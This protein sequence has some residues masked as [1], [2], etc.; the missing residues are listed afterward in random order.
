MIYCDIL[1]G[2]W[3][4]VPDLNRRLLLRLSILLLP[5]PLYFT[6]STSDLAVPLF[7][8]GIILS[9]LFY[10]VFY[11]I[12]YCFSV[13][14]V[15]L[16]CKWTL[17]LLALL[18]SDSTPIHTQIAIVVVLLSTILTHIVLVLCNKQPRIKQS[19]LAVYALIV[20][21]A[22]IEIAALSHLVQS[23]FVPWFASW[24]FQLHDDSSSF[25]LHDDSSS[26]QLHDDSSSFQLHD[27]SSSLNWSR[28]LFLLYWFA[29]IA[30][31]CWCLGKG[32]FTNQPQII[33]RKFF[34]LVAVILFLPALLTDAPFMQYASRHLFMIRVAFAFA[35]LVFLLLEIVRINSVPPF[36]SLDAVMRAFVDS[37][38]AGPLL[39]THFSLLLSCAAPSWVLCNSQIACARIAR[40]SGVLSVG[41][42]DAC[43]GDVVWIQ[44]RRR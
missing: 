2:I 29:V 35:Y 42:G 25:Q 40:L 34:H 24:L 28:P 20:A 33:Q 5:I 14:E 43:V 1:F 12:R 16:F 6:P 38:D 19:P 27:D 39:L 31:M 36:T 9:I 22:S 8:S 32:L 30:A 18:F 10:R 26:F 17:I 21:G 44:C 13:S 4:L 11:R 37:R 7:L 23:P 15:I 41:V 3:G